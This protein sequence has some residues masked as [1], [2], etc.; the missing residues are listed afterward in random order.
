METLLFI[1][2]LFVLYWIYKAYGWVRFKNKYPILS[3]EIPAGILEVG[4]YV[5]FGGGKVQYLGISREEGLYFVFE[6]ENS[7]NN[8]CLTKS[9]LED[10]LDAVYGRY[11]LK[12]K[13]VPLSVR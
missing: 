4:D 13:R 3:A 11:G 1:A 9:Q 5:S 2:V 12:W 7:I 8:S 6:Q 10:R